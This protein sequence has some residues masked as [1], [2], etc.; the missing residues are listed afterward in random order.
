MHCHCCAML[1]LVNRINSDLN[2]LPVLIWTLG[3]EGSWRARTGAW[4]QW[5]QSLYLIGSP[6]VFTNFFQ[7]FFS[8]ITD[9]VIVVL[10]LQPEKIS[11]IGPISSCFLFRLLKIEKKIE[12]K[13]GETNWWK[14][15]WA[16]QLIRFSLFHSFFLQTIR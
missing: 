8:Q 14:P 4:P 9:Y 6:H 2:S 7:Q 13:I 12:E 16:D 15:V 3:K 5:G 10:I 1:V 11:L